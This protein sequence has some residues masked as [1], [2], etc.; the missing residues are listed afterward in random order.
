MKDFQIIKMIKYFFV[1]NASFSFLKTF[2]TL[3]KL[4]TRK[5]I[6]NSDLSRQ[7]AYNKLKH[8]QNHF[9]FLLEKPILKN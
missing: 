2:I 6:Q 5:I 3:A 9:Y 4:P 7:S 1:I 8:L